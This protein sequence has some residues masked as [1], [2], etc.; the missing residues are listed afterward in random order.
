MRT[1]RKFLAFNHF[2]NFY[3]ENNQTIKQSNNQTIKHS[4]KW[5]VSLFSVS[6]SSMN[7]HLGGGPGGWFSSGVFAPYGSGGSNYNN[8]LKMIPGI[9]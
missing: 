4:F 2:N 9:R 1:K 8:G 3:Y 7:W 6:S 5:L